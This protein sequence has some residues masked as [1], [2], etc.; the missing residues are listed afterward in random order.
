MGEP[1]GS[2]ESEAKRAVSSDSIA[3]VEGARTS[4]TAL[5]ARNAEAGPAPGPASALRLFLTGSG[6]RRTGATACLF[7]T[8]PAASGQCL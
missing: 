1:G 4:G 6:P 2:P 5:H 8:A 3:R 7:R